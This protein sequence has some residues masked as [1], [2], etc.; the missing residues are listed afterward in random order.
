MKMLKFNSIF[1]TDES[2]KDKKN[3]IWERKVQNKIF[4][5]S[6]KFYPKFNW[7]YR[8]FDCKKIDLLS[9]FRFLLNEIKVLGSNY[10]FKELI[11]S[12][13]E[14]NGIIIEVWWQLGI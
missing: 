14:F 12:N 11:W 9:Q 3:L 4:M 10:N 8:G 2:P 13:Q 7:I 6:I 5:D 1:F